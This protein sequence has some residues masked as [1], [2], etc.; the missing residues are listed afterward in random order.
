MVDR[1]RKCNYDHKMKLY[2][3]TLAFL[4]QPLPELLEV[5]DQEG[6]ALEFSSALP[7]RSDNEHLFLEY[8][9]PK[10]A[11][12]Y[13]PPPQRPFVLNLASEVDSIR[14]RSIE[15]CQRGLRLSQQAGSPFFSAHAGFCID[16]QP[17]ELGKQLR[18]TEQVIERKKCWSL[19]IE[20][21]QAVLRTAEA[22]NV[23]FYIENNVTAGMNLNVHGQNPLLASHIE[24]LVSLTAEV[25]H[26][27]FGL[28]LDTAH[29]KV[30]GRTLGF[31][32][33]KWLQTAGPYIKAIHHSDN[34]GLFDSNEALGPD[35]WFLEYLRAFSNIPQVL[36]VKKLE[37][38]AIN[39]QIDLLNHYTHKITL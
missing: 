13:F 26:A 19:F 38:Q 24:E 28:L 21:L 4:G 11:H 17:E 23:D 7:Y 34:N 39:R 18:Q 27:R 1:S 25:D 14:R 22:L 37:P 32:P 30:S 31:A 20:S 6:Y 5:A 8:P 15:H 33:E 29:L 12:N 9:H 10:L 2:V 36:E 16:P 3:S 35:Y